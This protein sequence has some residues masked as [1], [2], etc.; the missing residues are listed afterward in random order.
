LQPA[1]EPEAFRLPDEPPGFFAEERQRSTLAGV[2]G[3]FRLLAEL[4]RGGSRS[5]DR[6]RNTG[7]SCRSDASV[8]SSALCS[9]GSVAA[10]S[11]AS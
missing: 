11:V 5:S 10:G 6:R 3:L 9:C 1:D 2:C 8:C 7:L 4:E